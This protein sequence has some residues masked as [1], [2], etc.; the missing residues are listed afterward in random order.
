MAERCDL[1]VVG[2]GGVGSAALY[3][4]AA[5]GLDVV[6]IEAFEP[7]HR[8][9]SSHG[10]SRIIRLAYFED[11]R[12]VPMAQ[13]SLELWQRLERESGERIF[14]RTGGLDGGA[15]DGRLFAGALGSCE[16]HGLAHEV[17]DAAAVRQRFPAFRVRPGE[18][19]V[20][21]PDAG[22]LDPERGI[23]AHVRMAEA[24]GAQV[25]TG[26]RVLCWRVDED[27]ID[28]ELDN[29]RHVRA[30]SLILAAGPWSTEVLS[31]G[32]RSVALTAPTLNVER[33]VVGWFDP[34][35][36]GAFD[37]GVMPVFNHEGLEGHFYGFP[38][39]DGRGPKI[40]RFGHLHEHVDAPLPQS[41]TAADRELLQG[42]ADVHLRGAGSLHELSEGWFTHSNDGHFIVDRIPGLPVAVACGLSGHGYKF[43]PV[44]GESLALLACGDEPR[45][46][47]SHLRWSR[48]GLS[49][50][51][52]R[53]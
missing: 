1:A 14:E 49:G 50:R 7:A 37:P 22:S 9:G 35:E 34:P 44:L 8:Q 41:V 16:V 27:A 33:Q 17:L 24:L 19:F 10:H 11:A 12:Y 47:L 48:P 3:H 38:A 15:P 13:R 20:F 18:H 29:H 46:D 45:T 6:G 21:Q 5:M 23:E 43:A 2:I 26:C 25:M 53:R 28:L 40:G 30:K 31:S 51:P 36:R 52:S 39:L 4:A 32:P 42:W